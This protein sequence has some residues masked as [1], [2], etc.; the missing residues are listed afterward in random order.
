ME[1]FIL[2]SNGTLPDGA[3][4]AAVYIPELCYTSV[5]NFNFPVSYK[6]AS[7]ICFVNI[8]D[9]HLLIPCKP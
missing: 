8:Y 9:F 5:C 1:L 6:I 2:R 4:S 3:C 7:L